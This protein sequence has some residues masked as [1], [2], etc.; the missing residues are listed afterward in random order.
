[1]TMKKCAFPFK[2]KFFWS[3]NQVAAN[4][5]PQS[6]RKSSIPMITT[7]TDLHSHQVKK[8]TKHFAFYHVVIL[9]L[10]L[11][12]N[13]WVNKTRIHLS[14]TTRHFGAKTIR[15]NS[16]LE[17][18]PHPLFLDPVS[19]SGSDPILYYLKISLIFK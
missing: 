4:F 5:Q 2:K 13:K 10:N 18:S 6:T 9:L 7:K 8:N 15:A 1:M 16:T 12:L 3:S 19:R 17:M 11:G 14:K